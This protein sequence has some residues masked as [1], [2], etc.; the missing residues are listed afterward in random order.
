MSHAELEGRLGYVFLDPALLEL[1]LSHASFSHERDGGRGN[2]RLEFLG[3][4]VLG[5]VIAHELYAAHPDWSEGDLTRA[6]AALVNGRA[7]AQVARRLELPPKIRLG[8]TEQTSGGEQKDR[9]LA[10]VFEALIGA[11]YLDGGVAPA[12]AFLRRCFADDLAAAG[13]PLERDPKTALQE[14]AHAVHRATPS[15]VTVDDSGQD[16]DELRFRVEVRIEGQTFASGTGRSKRAAELAAARTAL[17]Q[18]EP[19]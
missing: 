10:N 15:Y 1:A 11:I 8:R 16:A 19:A 2:E 13:A 18:R 9:V 17:A 5:L 6:R 4:A 3:D 12:H 14:W 7:L